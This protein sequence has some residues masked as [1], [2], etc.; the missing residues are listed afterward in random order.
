MC[1]LATR[2]ETAPLRYLVPALMTLLRRVRTHNQLENDGLYIKNTENKSERPWDS[3]R[4]LGG[5]AV[6]ELLFQVIFFYFPWAAATA[7]HPQLECI[8]RA[9]GDT[10]SPRHT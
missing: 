4:H 7:A 2:G 10:R 5:V 8:R 3:C 9:I 1:M 6:E